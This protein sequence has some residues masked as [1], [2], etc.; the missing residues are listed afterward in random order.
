MANQVITLNGTL[1][2]FPVRGSAEK[3]L[4]FKE[5]A[6]YFQG[7]AG[8]AKPGTSMDLRSAAVAAT[9][10]L[11]LSTAS[12]TVGGVINGVTVTVTWGTSDTATAAAIAA[13]INASG[14]A[15]VSNHVTAT[16]ALGVVTLTAKQPGHGGN[17]VTL[18]ASG[19][20]V[21]ASGARLTGGT[22]TLTTYS[23]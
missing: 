17:A 2:E 7:L 19:T 4:E 5:L 23:L 15:L 9:G 6:N 3:G 10:T 14:N 12:G 11:T 16:S 20:G 13:A 22:H 1:S 18:A 21:T 8:G